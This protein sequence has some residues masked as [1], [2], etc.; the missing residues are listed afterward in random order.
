MKLKAA[1]TASTTTNLSLGNATAVAVTTT[2]VTLITIIDSDGTA[3]GTDGTVV[4]SISLPAGSVQIIQKDADQFIKA[5][6]TNAQYTP[7]ARSSY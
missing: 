7:V 6:V 4:G 3:S 5:S 1:N 2:A